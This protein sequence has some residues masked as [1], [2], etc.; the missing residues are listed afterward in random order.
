MPTRS[1]GSRQ[2]SWRCC[3]APY[4]IVN[5]WHNGPEVS[6]LKGAFSDLILFTRIDALIVRSDELVTEIT[7]L[8]KV[9]H[10]DIVL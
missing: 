9:R 1:N 2:K 8:A 4:T 7:A 3:S 6:K 5:F 10:R